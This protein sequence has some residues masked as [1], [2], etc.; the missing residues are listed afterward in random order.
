MLSSSK[1][2]SAGAAVLGRVVTMGGSVGAWPT[3]GL[4]MFLRGDQPGGRRRVKRW[5]DR[6]TEECFRRFD[7]LA[8]ETGDRVSDHGKSAY[9]DVFA[10]CTYE[11]PVKAWIL[12]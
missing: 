3:S 7:M 4:V 11:P 1:D 12:V 8:S 9:F 2:A 5:M 10:F 6:N